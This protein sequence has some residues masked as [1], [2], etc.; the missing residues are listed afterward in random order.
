MRRLLEE[1][2]PTSLEEYDWKIGDRKKY[3]CPRCGYPCRRHPRKRNRTKVGTLLDFRHFPKRKWR[4]CRFRTKKSEGKKYLTESQ[5]RQAQEDGRL[6]VIEKWLSEP[7]DREVDS[8]DNS[9]GQYR[10]VNESDDGSETDRPIG[11]YKYGIAQYPRVIETVQFICDYTDQFLYQDIQLPD[12]N[13]NEH[14]IFTDVFIHASHIQTYHR[15]K[16]FLYWGRI[17]R[18]CDVEGHLCICFGYQ[19]HCLY[20]AIPHRFASRRGWTEQSILNR[21]VVAAGYLQPTPK[22][23]AMEDSLDNLHRQCWKV[24]S[25]DWGA[26]GLIKEDLVRLLPHPDQIAWVE[27]PMAILNSEAKLQEPIEPSPARDNAQDEEAEKDTSRTD[28][29]GYRIRPGSIPAESVRDR[30]KSSS[31]EESLEEQKT[32]IEKIVEPI[33]KFPPVKFARKCISELGRLLT[34]FYNLLK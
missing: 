29:G 33:I 5:R 25:D 22:F 14:E 32:L 13:A 2:T 9:S 12:R 3:F 28:G 30:P 21:Y 17:E 1:G 24:V 7:N 15:R 19:D 31:M 11:R 23:Q 8:L 10:G 4:E 27:P 20:L 18:V 6:T 34:W 16:S 26:V